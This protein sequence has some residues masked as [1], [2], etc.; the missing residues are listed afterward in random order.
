MTRMCLKNKGS[1]SLKEQRT[2]EEDS[3]SR[4]NGPGVP[5]YGT[6]GKLSFL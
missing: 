6:Y 1:S 2:A 3:Q 5:A 4:I